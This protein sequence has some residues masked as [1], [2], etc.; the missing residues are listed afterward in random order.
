[1]SDLNT[2]P[3]SPP[4]ISRSAERTTPKHHPSSPIY[5]VF[6]SAIGVLHHMLEQN[7]LLT[8]KTY[9]KKVLAEALVSPPTKCHGMA[10][11][12][13][14]HAVCIKPNNAKQ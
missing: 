6:L 2:I 9:Q 12:N 14:R 8:D 11:S 3:E 13:M 4:E 5:E 1:M 7:Y 10:Q